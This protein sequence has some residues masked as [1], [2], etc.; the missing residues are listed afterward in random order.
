MPVFAMAEQKLDKG[1]PDE[2]WRWVQLVLS[3]LTSWPPHVYV[4]L[5]DACNHISQEHPVG[6]GGVQHAAACR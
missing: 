2:T 4:L 1:T 3:S 5:A 6:G